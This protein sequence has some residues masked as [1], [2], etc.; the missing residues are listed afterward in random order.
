RAVG[1]WPPADHSRVLR[2]MRRAGLPLHAS[3]VGVDAVMDGM[4]RD[5]KRVDG[6]LRFVLPMAI[7]DVRHGIE[8]GGDV[9]RAAVEQC[10]AAPSSAELAG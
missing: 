10:L 6:R 8:V 9:V 5:K 7:G 2:A 1:G 3:G 4:A